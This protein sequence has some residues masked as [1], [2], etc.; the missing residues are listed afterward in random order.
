MRGTELDGSTGSPGSDENGRY[1][2]V[3]CFQ[4]Q[5]SGT[6][7]SSSFHSGHMTT[8]VTSFAHYARVDNNHSTADRPLPPAARQDCLLKFVL[9][10]RDVSWICALWVDRCYNSAFAHNLQDPSLIRR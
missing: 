8:E 2:H 5:S 3:D 9:E 6:A 1:E 7:W 10:G 4:Y